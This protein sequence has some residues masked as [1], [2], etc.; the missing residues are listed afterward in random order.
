MQPKTDLHR[1][2]MHEVVHDGVHYFTHADKGLP[3]LVRDLVLKGGV[4]AREFVN[5]KRKKYFSP[6]NFFCSLRR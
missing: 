5:G 2:S 4:V 6:L 3:Q 1:I